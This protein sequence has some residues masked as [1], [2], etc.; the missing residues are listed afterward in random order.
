M[1][2]ED[3]VTESAR[4]YS[5]DFQRNTTKTHPNETAE[6]LK[7]NKSNE[8][9]IPKPF[10]IR[11]SEDCLNR[12]LRKMNLC[13]LVTHGKYIVPLVYIKNTDLFKS[14]VLKINRM[15]NGYIFNIC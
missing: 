10:K 11:W 12:I 9:N 15:L 3:T 7:K 2:H 6:P 8:Q 4:I 13:G 1:F 14:I 5:K